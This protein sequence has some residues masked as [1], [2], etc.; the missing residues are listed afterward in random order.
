[1]S[2]LD[3]RKFQKIYEIVA[4]GIALAKLDGRF[5]ECN[6]A[7]SALTGYS[8]DELRKI[9]FL[10]LIHPEELDEIKRRVEAPLEGRESE[11]EIENRYVALMNPLILKM[12]QFRHFLALQRESK[13]TK[14]RLLE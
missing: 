14:T 7:Y 8:Q 6:A 12:A 5:V 9:Q 10:S 13:G 3:E 4:T 11:F 2:E 1:M